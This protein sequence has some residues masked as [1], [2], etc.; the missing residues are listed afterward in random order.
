VRTT[1]TAIVSILAALTFLGAAG[2]AG[3]ATFSVD[4]TRIVLSSDTPTASVTIRNTGTQ[5][6]RFQMSAFA[7]RQTANGEMQLDPTDAVIFFPRLVTLAPGEQRAVRVGS[8]EPAGARERAY[9]LFI[10]ELPPLETVVGDAQGVRVLTRMGVPVFIRPDTA[11]MSATLENLDW[12]AGRLVFSLTNT[13]SVHILPEWVSV[14]AED[15]RGRALASE[16]VS[17]WY[18]LAGERRDFEVP[19][20]VE[21]CGR[22]RSLGVEVAFGDAILRERLPALTGACLE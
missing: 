4:P 5:A 21:T 10:E 6:L 17:A 8:P 14:R 11:E 20:T 7:W 18:V 12:R 2:V 1:R 15:D 9:R 16:D 13:G 3:A 19:L 22:V